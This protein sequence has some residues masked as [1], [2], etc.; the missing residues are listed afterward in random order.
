MMDANFE[1]NCCHMLPAMQT[2]GEDF[3]IWQSNREWYSYLYICSI[4]VWID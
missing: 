1:M 3:Y 4:I 2:N